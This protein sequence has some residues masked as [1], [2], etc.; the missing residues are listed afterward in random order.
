MAP[1]RP[2]KDIL[3]RLEPIVPSCRSAHKHVPSTLSEIL[4][5]LE[6]QGSF[7][8]ELPISLSTS[9]D[10]HV[11]AQLNVVASRQE[12]PETWR[13]SLKI[14]REPIDLID[15]HPNDPHWHRHRW[16]REHGIK[17]DRDILHNFQPNSLHEF[18]EKSF[19]EMNI[20]PKPEGNSGV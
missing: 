10:R 4:A 19:E 2:P 12:Y 17:S 20:H 5:A 13:I 7:K 18:L 1:K 15:R 16:N 3:D 9:S 11:V 8:K 6:K 14:D